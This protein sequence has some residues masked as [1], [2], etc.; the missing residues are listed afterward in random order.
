MNRLLLALLV[1]FAVSGCG[2]KPARSDPEG[3]RGWSNDTPQNPLHERA[4]HQG[5]RTGS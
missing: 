1:A 2:E 3:S 5:E 4:R